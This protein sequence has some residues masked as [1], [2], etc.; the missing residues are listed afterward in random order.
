MLPWLSSIYL[1]GKAGWL[2]KGSTILTTLIFGLE[3]TERSALHLLVQAQASVA[4]VS[5]PPCSPIDF[6]PITIAALAGGIVLIIGSLF[7][8]VGSLITIARTVGASAKDTEAIKGHVNSEKTAMEGQALTLKAEN[9]LLR[10]MVADQKV[11]AERLA[12]SVQTISL[13]KAIAP[14]PIVLAAGALPANGVTAA[15]AESPE[16]LAPA[17]REGDPRA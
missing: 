13:A 5:V 17:T 6:S 9:I 8:G 2:L 11:I 3:L 16:R 1:T 10:Q 15:V 12:A 14:P 7:A 4:A